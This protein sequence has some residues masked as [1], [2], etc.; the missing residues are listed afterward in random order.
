MVLTQ[1]RRG[2]EAE[3]HLSGATQT[4][5]E[6]LSKIQTPRFRQSLVRAERVREIYDRLG[7]R[8]PELQN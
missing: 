4:I 1:L 7:R 3:A 8:L 6:I 2:K 5:E